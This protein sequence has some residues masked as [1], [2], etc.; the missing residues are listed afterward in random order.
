MNMRSF[1]GSILLIALSACAGSPSAA[2]P[3]KPAGRA[4]NPSGTWTEL[5]PA[6]LSG[7]LESKDFFMVNVHIPYA[8]ELPMTDAFIPF[9]RIASRLAELPGREGKIVLYCRTG[10]MSE[11]ALETLSAAGYSNLFELE[12]GFEAWRLAGLQFIEPA[13]G[14]GTEGE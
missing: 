14:R 4:T 13:S 9:D 2:P 12:G 5:T 8:G 7:M 3:S 1:L 10:R 6:D 11:A